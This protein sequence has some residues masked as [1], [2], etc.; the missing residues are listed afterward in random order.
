MEPFDKYLD[1][2][3]YAAEMIRRNTTQLGEASY[4]SMITGKYSVIT[5]NLV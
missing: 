3:D 1:L 4:H 2:F 5:G